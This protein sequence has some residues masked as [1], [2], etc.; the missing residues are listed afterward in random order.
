MHTGETTERAP[1]EVYY[2]KNAM[3][4]TIVVIGVRYRDGQVDNVSLT[5]QGT[6]VR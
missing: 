3:G 4:R 5:Y 2:V 6:T 1:S